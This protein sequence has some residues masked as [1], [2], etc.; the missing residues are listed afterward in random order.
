M[1]LLARGMKIQLLSVYGAIA[2]FFLPSFQGYTA[3]TQIDSLWHQVKYYYDTKKYDSAIILADHLLQSAKKVGDVSHQIKSMSKIAKSFKKKGD[4]DK[5]VNT[6]Y[7]LLEFAESI[8]SPH[9]RGS[10]CLN[11]GIIFFEAYD[12]DNA[13]HYFKNASN[14]YELANKPNNQS[15]S[16]YNIGF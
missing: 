7:D 10:A 3:N 14:Q 6:F 5:C 4:F 8:N 16:L 2:I 1:R 13:I 15:V 12:Y 9:G 11:L